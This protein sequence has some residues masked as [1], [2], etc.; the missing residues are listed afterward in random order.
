VGRGR[1]GRGSAATLLR[2]ARPAGTGVLSVTATPHDATAPAFT[3]E[4]S[5]LVDDQPALLRRF[6]KRPAGGQSVELVW[7]E[8]DDLATPS[9]QPF[10]AFV[11]TSRTLATDPVRVTLLAGTVRTV[12]LT[13]PVCQVSLSGPAEE[14]RRLALDLAGMPLVSARIGSLAE[15]ALLILRRPVSGTPSVVPSL[16]ASLPVGEACRE[17]CA[18]L[19]AQIARAGALITADPAAIP[20]DPEPVHQMRV[21]LRRLRSMLALFR[22]AVACAPFDDMT[23]MLKPLG[24]ILGPARDW[25]VFAGGTGRRAANAFPDEPSVRRLLAASRHRQQASYAALRAYL[26]S[27]AYRC[28]GIEFACLVGAPPWRQAGDLPQDAAPAWA[29]PLGAFARRAL[30]RRFRRLRAP[31]ADIAALPEVELHAIR[32]QAKRMRYAA[33]CFAPL[34]GRHATRRFI[35]RVASLQEALGHLNDGAVTAALMAQLRPAIGHGFAGGIIRGMVIAESPQT[36]QLIQV[37]W[38]R[39]RQ[40]PAF[41]E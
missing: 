26:A 25:D 40:T 39:L 4:L 31:G 33:E 1:R 30:S 10:A 29:D 19:A 6:G 37:A 12:T 32:L 2:P 34:F 17:V 14:V 8:N 3:L 28:L 36:R 41:W 20:A 21:A 18:H 23:M 27:P 35:R 11:G 15:A 9:V 7:H 24:T 5:L 16:A 13:R 38:E 22:S